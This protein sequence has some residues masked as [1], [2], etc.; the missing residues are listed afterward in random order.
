M[1]TYQTE[2]D[3]CLANAIG[4]VKQELGSTSCKTILTILLH[5]ESRLCQ[6]V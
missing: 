3:I 5:P 1:Q 6:K 2:H 4:S